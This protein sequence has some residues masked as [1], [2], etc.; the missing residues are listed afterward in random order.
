MVSLVAVSSFVLVACVTEQ[1]T[2]VSGSSITVV[3]DEPFLS[4]NGTPSR[5]NT[6]A[7]TAIL[8]M[9]NAGFTSYTSEPALARDESFGT[10]DV[11]AEDPLTVQYT[12]NDETQWSDGVA[13]DAADMLL[14]WVATTGRLNDPDFDP[15]DYTDPDT[16][17]F[18]DDYPTDVVY[19]DG[20][21]GTGLDL[22]AFP[23][24]DGKTLTLVYD[25][26]FVDWELAFDVGLPAHIVAGKA[27]EIDD[28]AEAKQAF[29]D[30][31]AGNDTV[32]LAAISSF[33][34]TG[35]TFTEM[36]DDL[37]LLVGSGPYLITELV[38]EEFI[39]VE[40]NENY[41]GDQAP[42]IEKI[43]VRFVA[44]ALEA[45]QAF[46]DGEADVIS[47]RATPE[48][49][50]AISELRS[51]TVIWGQ[52]NL[53]QHLDLMFDNSK[54]GTFDNPAL[55]A[56]FVKTVP[57]EG[58]I[59]ALGSPVTSG[60]PVR[61]S[62]LFLPGSPGYVEATEVNGM[63]DAYDAVDIAGAR[64]LINEAGVDTPTVC[65]LYAPDNPRL[66]EEFSIIRESAT[67]AGFVVD[68]CSSPDWRGLL[69]TPGHHD[70]SL[71][72]W[73]TRSL[74]V[75]NAVETFRSEG[76]NNLNYYS[77]SRVDELLDAL[78]VE[79]DPVEKIAIQLEVDTLLVNDVY[80]L[81]LYQFP[82][83]TAV[84]PRV[85]NVGSSPMAP[86]IFWNV[87]AWEPTENN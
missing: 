80:G 6:A 55:R 7:D 3:W 69:G 63:A 61:D 74:G 50:A 44:D 67:D 72:A 32:A 49:T 77:N 14:A 52:E 27:L 54:N 23:E 13:V 57:R 65:V 40:A 62:H 30:A 35:F 20:A 70:A 31:V 53:H 16:G 19:F 59:D 28:P 2:V 76:V 81:T 4:Y 51:A 84:S 85:T 78:A 15:G 86:T 43:S 25:E 18:T 9:T 17:M 12:I 5:A 37:D 34:N 38:A 56:A 48:V 46:A 79:I 42:A 47:T 60:A 39:T 41:R 26:F 11:V 22:T 21:R 82:S 73:Q 1:S 58:I 66:A 33:W 45:V 36:P 8:S 29:I 71:F 64:A 87:W 75:T 24:F 83:V 68:D 10:Y